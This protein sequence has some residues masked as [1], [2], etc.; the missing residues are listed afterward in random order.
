[1][2]PNDG[3]PAFPGNDLSNSVANT[4]YMGMSLRDWFA[5]QALAG[6]MS[7]QSPELGEW[8][9]DTSDEFIKARCVFLYQFADAML[10]AR[11]GAK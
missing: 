3:G 7:A 8:T 4:S 11:G 6:D 1:M 9:N 10:A 5:G 2:T